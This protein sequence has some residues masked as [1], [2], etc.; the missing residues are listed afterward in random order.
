MSQLYKMGG[1]EGSILREDEPRKL[2]PRPAVQHPSNDG[3]YNVGYC[4][5]CPCG[6]RI[7][8]IACPPHR[9]TVNVDGSVTINGSCGYHADHKRPQN[10]C[11]F[12]ITNGRFEIHGDS[13]CPGKDL[14][15]G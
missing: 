4:F 14:G 13:Q 15:N 8:A 3:E 1:E 6:E 11:H 12:T 7:V 5:W 9:V 2:I 10:W